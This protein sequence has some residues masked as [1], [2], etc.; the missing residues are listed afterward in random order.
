MV[1]LHHCAGLGQ[2]GAEGREGRRAWAPGSQ[3]QPLAT[4]QVTLGLLGLLTWS[5]H[6]VL[7]PCSQAGAQP[8]L[9][10]LRDLGNPRSTRSLSFP[11]GHVMLLVQCGPGSPH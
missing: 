8:R 10:R 5:H 6:E 3:S 4:S 11:L 9:H 2:M 7:T 1:P